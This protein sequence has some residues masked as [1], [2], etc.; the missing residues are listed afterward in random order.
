MPPSNHGLGITLSLASLLYQIGTMATFDFEDYVFEQVV[1]LVESYDIKLP[2]DFHYLIS[3]ILIKQKHDIVSDEDEIGFPPMLLSFSYKLFAK[4]HVP[5][6]ALPNIPNFDESHLTARYN[7][8]EVSPMF[9][10]VRSCLL[11]VLMRESKVLHEIISSSNTRKCVVEEL[12]QM[13]NPEATS[14]FTSQV[15]I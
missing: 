12:I 14:A 1:K 15:V 4:K 10:L 9:M 7:V 2:I 5:N 3:G 11:N 13:M 6:I 8:L